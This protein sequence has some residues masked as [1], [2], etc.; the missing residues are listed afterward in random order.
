M[1][2]T[3]LNHVCTKLVMNMQYTYSFSL[4]SAS[5]YTQHRSSKY[6]GEARRL[7]LTW[8]GKQPSKT[9]PGWVVA[10][11][12]GAVNLASTRWNYAKV[13]FSV[14]GAQ[15][16]SSIT[17]VTRRSQLH[18]LAQASSVETAIYAA[19]AELAAMVKRLQ[20]VGQWQ[21]SQRIINQPV[22]CLLDCESNRDPFRHQLAKVR[23]APQGHALRVNH[24]TLLMALGL[25]LVFCKT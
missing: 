9:G 8:E 3:T 16:P 25:F 11:A 18:L 17:C 2:A 7:F 24:S 14:G 13:S 19:K 1:I 4:C 21:A 15:T 10:F 5:M 12:T 23:Q 22:Q 6:G 20:F